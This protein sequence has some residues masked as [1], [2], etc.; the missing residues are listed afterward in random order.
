MSNEWRFKRNTGCEQWMEPV[1][2]EGGSE[3]T[4]EAWEKAWWEFQAEMQQFE[5][6]VLYARKNY[7]QRMGMLLAEDPRGKVKV[8]NGG[9]E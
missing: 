2:K 6:D 7:L 9:R 8:T 4:Q 1:S 5:E 3:L